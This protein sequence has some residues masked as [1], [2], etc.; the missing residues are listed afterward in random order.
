MIAGF[1]RH[2]CEREEIDGYFR[3]FIYL[4]ARE[5]LVVN[6]DRELKL[7]IQEQKPMIVDE[8][9][10][11][12]EAFQQ[13]HKGVQVIYRAQSSSKPNNNFQ[14]RNRGRNTQQQ[15]IVDTRTCFVCNRT[16]HIATDCPMQRS[17]QNTS[18]ENTNQGK[19][20]LCISKT[21]E[22]LRNEVQMADGFISGVTLNLT[23]ISGSGKKN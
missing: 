22:M 11:K 14:N 21:E 2:W 18:R 19:F 1:L 12:A 7:W 15:K 13:A 5:E 20:G 23:W 4:I 17:S 10:E 16:G 3:K 8:L 6:C 9:I